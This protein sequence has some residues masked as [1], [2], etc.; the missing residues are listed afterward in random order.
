M[1]PYQSRVVEEKEQLDERLAKLL[2]FLQTD[3]YR[4]L[5][6]E[7]RIRLQLQS[8]A[9]QQYLN[10]LKERIAAFIRKYDG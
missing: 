2:E 10:I 9:M 1:Q 4:A 3:T 6:S 5:H 8:V 7:E